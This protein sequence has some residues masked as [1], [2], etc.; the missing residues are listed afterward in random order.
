MPDPLYFNP[1]SV[2]GFICF[3]NFKLYLLIILPFDTFMVFAKST[4][5]CHIL[6]SLSSTYRTVLYSF[7]ALSTGADLV[8][9]RNLSVSNLLILVVNSTDID[10][11]ET[12]LG[13]VKEYS[14]YFSVKSRNITS[15]ELDLTIELRIKDGGKLLWFKF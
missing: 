12:I 1:V 4:V 13:K 5:V 14:K 6:S 2:A 9:Y 8:A 7:T 11:E 15:S 10:S 3:F